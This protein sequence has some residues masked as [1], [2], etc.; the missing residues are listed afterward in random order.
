[1]PSDGW[2]QCSRKEIEVEGDDHRGV[3]RKGVPGIEAGV[4]GSQK[5]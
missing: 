1:M 3:I 4:G 2:E 5:M